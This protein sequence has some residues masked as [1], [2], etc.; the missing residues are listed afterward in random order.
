VLQC[1]QKKQYARDKG[2]K[3]AV[4][5]NV[6]DFIAHVT[7]ALRANC[8]DEDSYYYENGASRHIRV[9]IHL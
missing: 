4:K 1:S 5:K 7:E 9:G 6:D 8:D 3:S 2:G